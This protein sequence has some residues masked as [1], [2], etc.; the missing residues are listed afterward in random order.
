M[1]VNSPI[2]Y[3]THRWTLD[4]PEDFEMLSWVAVELKERGLF[5]YH[6]EILQILAENPEIRKINTHL[7]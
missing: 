6:P 1:A 4:Y 3:S 2:D 7:S 5:G